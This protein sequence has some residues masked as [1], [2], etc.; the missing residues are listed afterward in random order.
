VIGLSKIAR[1]VEMFS[2]RLQVQERLGK[3]V[4]LAL[5]EILHPQGIGVV[6]EAGHLCMTMRGVQKAGAVTTTFCTL[7]R[8]QSSKET[9][10]EF[11][12][13]IGRRSSDNY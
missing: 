8:L 13:L 4:A 9:R 3:E 12:Q 1:I 11:L 2:R 7:G 6:V 10:E 5:S